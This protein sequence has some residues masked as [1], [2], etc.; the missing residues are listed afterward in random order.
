MGMLPLIF[1]D[2]SL[3][4]TSLSTPTKTNPVLTNQLVHF[5][6]HGGHYLYGSRGMAKL[7]PLWR[8]QQRHL[9]PIPPRRS[10]FRGSHAHSYR[11]DG[12]SLVESASRVHL[13]TLTSSYSSSFLRRHYKSLTMDFDDYYGPEWEPWKF[14]MTFDDFWPLINEFNTV[15]SV[16]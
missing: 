15:P 14:D 9:V 13:G 2:C 10:Y 5:K 3:P 6:P 11:R 8:V 16:I 1:Q 7:Q 12:A 4:T